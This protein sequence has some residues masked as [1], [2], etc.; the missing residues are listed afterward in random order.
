MGLSRDGCYVHSPL[1]QIEAA[2]GSES[3]NLVSGSVPV[4]P[5]RSSCLIKRLG[6]AVDHSEGSC[7]FGVISAGVC[8]A[9]VQ[10]QAVLSTLRVLAPCLHRS[11]RSKVLLLPH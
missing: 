5:E 4:S 11:P 7:P 2:W 1:G 6:L 10:P 9:H 3:W 8:R